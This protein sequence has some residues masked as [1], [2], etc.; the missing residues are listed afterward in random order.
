[1]NTV[2]RNKEFTVE[3]ISNGF[4]FKFNGRDDDNNW[5]DESFYVQELESVNDKMISWFEMEIDK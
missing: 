3:Q 4:L 1:M 5:T 2:K